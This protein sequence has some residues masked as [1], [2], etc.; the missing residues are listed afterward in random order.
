M[1][2]FLLVIYP[3]SSLVSHLFGALLISTALIPS[4]FILTWLWNITSGMSLPILQGIIRCIGFGLNYFIFI[5]TLLLSIILY[6]QV[7]RLKNQE[8]RAQIISATGIRLGAY[9]W[10][11]SIAIHL[12]LPLVRTTPLAVW[13][14]RGMGAKIGKNTIISTPRLWDC[15]LLEI[16]DHCV[17]GGNAAISCHITSTMGRGILKKVKIGNRVTI[18][19]DTMIFPGTTIGDNVVV[20]AG[21]IVPQDSVLESH[22]IYSGVPVEKI[23]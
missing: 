19:A 5:N 8:A 22:S 12:A 16:G 6:R 15:D 17:I 2:K 3:F 13:F 11:I 9:N 20:A 1:K 10:M 18:G 7:F 21:S 23:R 4:Y 14:Y